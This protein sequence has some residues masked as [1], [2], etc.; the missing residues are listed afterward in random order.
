MASDVQS[1]LSQLQLNNYTSLVIVVAISYDYCLTFSREVTYIWQR[2]WTKVS[3]LFLLIRYVGCLFALALAFN[4]SGFIP[5]P[6]K[7]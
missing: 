6:V 4:Q 3:T 2:P 5:G 1:L 7:V